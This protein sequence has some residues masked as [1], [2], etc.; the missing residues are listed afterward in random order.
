[1]AAARATCRDL[2]A[3]PAVSGYVYGVAYDAV[4]YA[5]HSD[6][7]RGARHS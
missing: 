7:R 1:M 3:D 6:T 4:E 2:V 5:R